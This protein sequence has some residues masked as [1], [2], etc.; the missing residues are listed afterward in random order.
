VRF[1]LRVNNDLKIPDY[2]LLA[3]TAEAAGFDQFWVSDDLFL[4]SAPVLVA[5]MLQATTR[6][7]IGIGILNPYTI[8]PSEIAMLAAT[9]DELSDCRF[10]LGLAAGAARFLRWVGIEPTRPLAATRATIDAVRGLL[11]GER[12]RGDGAFLPWTED[13]YLRFKAPRVTP[14][15]LGAM[16][17]GMLRLIGERADGA[18]PLLLPPDHYFAVRPLVDE[19]LARRP[20]ALGELDFA[21]CIW[22]SLAE[23][24]QAA[25]RALAEKIAYYGR[26]LGP[27]IHARLGVTEDDFAP[28]ERAMVTERD[29]DKA[30]GLVDERMLRIGVVGDPRDVIAQLEPLVAAGVRH[31]SFGPPLGPDPLAAV[32]LLGREVLPHFRRSPRP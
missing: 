5:A 11:A 24:R 3:R 13:A 23:D 1:S 27:L 22:V 21:A 6:L 29:V 12:V 32:A 18:L 26:A 30:V 7:E 19:G 17:P 8:H 10:N 14:I 2:V 31:L 9:L 28:I 16:S 4:R 20:A 25:R 15:Y